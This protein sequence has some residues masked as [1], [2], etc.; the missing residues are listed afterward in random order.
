MKLCQK[1]DIENGIPAIRPNCLVRCPVTIEKVFIDCVMDLKWIVSTSAT[2]PIH[3]DITVEDYQ[4]WIPKLEALET[5]NQN[6]DAD[7][8]G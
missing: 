7:V 5:R 8:R 4:T 2:A 1:A 6:L 3:P